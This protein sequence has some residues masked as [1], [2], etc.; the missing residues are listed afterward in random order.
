[1]RKAQKQPSRG[2]RKNNEAGLIY[3]PAVR[4]IPKMVRTMRYTASI[5]D[6]AQ[7][8]TVTGGSLLSIIVAPGNGTTGIT[9]PVDCIK[10][11]SVEV[12]GITDVT[13]NIRFIW[14]ESTAM[15]VD[16]ALMGNGTKPAHL[17]VKPPRRTQAEEAFTASMP[18][19][20]RNQTVFSIV[21]QSPVSGTNGTL[22]LD[23]KFE[24]VLA[25]GTMITGVGSST[26][27]LLSYA[28]LDGIAT[29]LG[30]GTQKLVPLDLSLSTLVSRAS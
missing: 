20:I 11:K 12:W 21:W 25:N 3:P 9:F 6:A 23:I 5:T 30:A 18:S 1:M 15:D 13:H 26:S 8:A 2:R 22:V 16:Y 27:T 29:G 28:H 7:S 10:I 4:A 19:T 14:S 17:K 24:Y